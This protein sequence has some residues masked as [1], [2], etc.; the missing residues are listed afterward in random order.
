MSRLTASQKAL[1]NTKPQSSEL[2]LSIYKP[3]TALACRVNNASIAKGDRVIAYDSVTEGNHELVEKDFI[4]LVGTTLGGSEKGRIRVRSADASEITVQANS[5]INWADNDYITILRY[6]EIV[7]IYQRIIQDPANPLNTLWYKDYDIAYTDQNSVLGSFV[8]MGGHY[9]GFVDDNVYYTASGTNNF[10]GDALTYDW[11]MEGA[12]TTGSSAGT[13]GYQSYSTAGHYVTRLEVDNAS[14]G[15]DTSYRFVSLYDRPGEGSNPPILQWEMDDLKE[16]RQAAGGRTRIR[17]FEDIDEDVIRPNA[18][19][20]I[21]GEDWWGNTRN[22]WGGEDLNRSTTFFVGYI[23]EGTINW[24]YRQGVVEFEVVSPTEIMKEVEA[25]S[26]DLTSSTDPAGQA[27]SD[28][29]FPSGWTLLLDL[30]VERAIYH[31]LRW[32]STVLQVM[33]VEF[34]GTDYEL[35]SFS[36]DR[37]SI[38][39]GV[40]TILNAALVGDA[41]C[42]RQGKLWLEISAMA[43]DDAANSFDECMTMEKQFWMSEPSLEVMEINDLSYLEMGGVAYDGPASDT[44]NAYLACAPGEEPGPQG[45]MEEIQGLALAD[46]DQL[47]T[48]VGNI[49]AWRN[50]KY[51]R[52]DY[53]LS[54]PFKNINIAP[55]EIVRVDLDADDTPRRVTFSNKAFMVQEIGWQY[56]SKNKRL[57]QN[58]ALHEVTQ[59]FDGDTIVI[60][61]V[62][63]TDG[64]DGGFDTPPISV[65]PIPPITIPAF[66]TALQGSSIYGLTGPIADSSGTALNWQ[67]ADFDDIGVF[68]IA[69]G[70][71]TTDIVIPTAGQYQ[72]WLHAYCY[73]RGQVPDLGY[74]WSV[75]DACDIEL[76]INRESISDLSLV[77]ARD[78]TTIRDY[79]VNLNSI[80][81]AS[82][83][84][85]WGLTVARTYT[86]YGLVRTYDPGNIAQPNAWYIYHHLNVLKLV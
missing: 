46:Q 35:D 77:D 82:T 47:N 63:P 45:S 25:F 59:G 19:V 9:A 6:V 65:P 70:I 41:V 38:Y 37:T 62:P 56:D 33:D 68:T 67:L 51:P 20:V 5:H 39:D 71:S 66:S 54:V 81:L 52:L 43:T 85:T 22:T 14:G 13:P 60:P 83:D 16:S 40:Q 4:M 10:K 73:G 50:A 2:Y 42:N 32:H 58:I 76:L 74:Q 61:N 24:D 27:S 34:R 55:Q 78:V 17:I 31:L 79:G 21:F 23:R 26:I 72:L 12:T 48:L 69:S 86:I 28:A 11:W 64:E 7:P 36:S 30:D 75:T 49:Y 18:L 1:A 84:L 8:C 29:N 80:T 44:F 15:T 53:Y 3:Q 57:L